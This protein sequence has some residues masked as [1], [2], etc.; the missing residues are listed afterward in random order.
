MKYCTSPVRVYEYT[1]SVHSKSTYF[2]NWMRASRAVGA[3]SAETSRRSRQ[4]TPSCGAPAPIA[5]LR[6]VRGS[7]RPEE[8]SSYTISH[9]MG[10]EVDSVKTKMGQ[11]LITKKAFGD[12]VE[13]K[14]PMIHEVRWASA[15]E[16]AAPKSKLNRILEEFSSSC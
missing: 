3:E 9:E 1:G 16:R 7:T 4:T 6:I 14:S 10:N 8:A 12:D 2:A 13:I 5:A 15:L 11:S